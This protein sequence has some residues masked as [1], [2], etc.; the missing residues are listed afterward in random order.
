MQL[1]GSGTHENENATTTPPFSSTIDF[2]HPGADPVLGRERLCGQALRSHVVS[3]RGRLGRL[4]GCKHRPRAGRK[5]DGKEMEEQ[6]GRSPE[7]A[8]EGKGKGRKEDGKQE[9]RK[10]RGME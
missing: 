9:E 8:M 3:H 4:E 5:G 1:R 10:E 7:K 6:K 2:L